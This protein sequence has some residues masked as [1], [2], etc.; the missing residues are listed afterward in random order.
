M[1][2]EKKTR[3]KKRNLT[4]LSMKTVPYKTAISIIN[5]RI[6]CNQTLL[7]RKSLSEKNRVNLEDLLIKLRIEK[8]KLT[9]KFLDSESEFYIKSS[10]DLLVD[11]NKQS[12]RNQI[13]SVNP[14][15][16]TSLSDIFERRNLQ[17]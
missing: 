5:E 11:L 7:K 13:S 8:K 4:K 17:S 15:E 10:A 6:Y 14:R 9:E 2:D 12:I 16:F 1:E 3:K